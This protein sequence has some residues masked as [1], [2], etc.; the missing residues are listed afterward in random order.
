[1]RPIVIGFVLLAA[2]TRFCAAHEGPAGHDHS[3]DGHNHAPGAHESTER[4]ENKA[5]TYFW[6]KS[7]EAFH[8][9]DYERVLRLHKAIVALDPKDTQS[10]GV[11]AWIAWSMGD[12]KEAAEHIERGLAANPDDWEMWE[13]AA[14]QYQF[15]KLWPQAQKAYA[16]TIQLAPKEENTL[17]LRRQLA[18][19]AQSAGDLQTSVETWRALVKDFPDDAVN[20]NNLERVEKLMAEKSK[21]PV[22]TSCLESER[23]MTTSVGALAV[24]IVPSLVHSGQYASAFIRDVSELSR[25]NLPL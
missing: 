22:Q 14:Q 24:M 6:T 10:Y 8:A 18:H 15:M 5:T 11:Y 7:D 9:G 23:L 4:D 17:M 12:N 21:A 19:V 3:H 25:Q 16:Q 13:A 1:M 2:S 20:K